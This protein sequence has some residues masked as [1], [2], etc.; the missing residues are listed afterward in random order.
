MCVSGYMVW[1]ATWQALRDADIAQSVRQQAV[2]GTPLCAAAADRTPL[3]LRHAFCCA[4]GMKYKEQRF[5]WVG[6]WV[7]ASAV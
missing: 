4:A 1:L 7:R 5:R 2:P 6:G 3:L